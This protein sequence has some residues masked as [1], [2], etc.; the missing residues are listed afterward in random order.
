MNNPPFPDNPPENQI[1]SWCDTDYIKSDGILTKVVNHKGN[2][3]RVKHL[4]SD[5]ISYLL[6][7]GDCTW[8]HGATLQ[9][10]KRDLLYK[11]SNRDTSMYRMY[12]LD[13]ELALEAAVECYRAITG[14]CVLGIKA[15]LE[16]GHI[17]QEVLTIRELIE[18]TR[19]QFGHACFESF[20]T[21]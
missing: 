20:F 5:T 17:A 2:V 18:V 9:D 15:F 1:F 10:A 21:D 13:T 7:D 3:Y 6:S 16:A 8:A 19:D 14:A 12:T 11:I 4:G